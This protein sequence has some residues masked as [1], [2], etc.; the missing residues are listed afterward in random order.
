MSAL[1]EVHDLSVFHGQLEAV[2]GV[3][4]SVDAG[5]VLVVI[6]ANGAGKS[7]LLRTI[8]GLHTPAAGMPSSVGT[9]P[10][11]PDLQKSRLSETR[12]APRVSMD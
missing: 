11:A 5:Q 10:Q 8:A 2:R 6:G 4:V 3:S 1:L 12:L 9:S 7:T